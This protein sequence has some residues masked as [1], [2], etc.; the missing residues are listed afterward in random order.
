MGSNLVGHMK[1]LPR[2]YLQSNIAR[3]YPESLNSEVFMLYISNIVFL[4]PKFN[5]I[6]NIKIINKKIKL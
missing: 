3:S 5:C 4:P 1:I 6:W 2:K